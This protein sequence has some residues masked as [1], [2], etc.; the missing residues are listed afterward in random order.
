MI[1]VVIQKKDAKDCR[2]CGFHSNWNLYY[3][4]DLDS[5]KRHIDSSKLKENFSHE[6]WA[7]DDS[8]ASRR[9]TKNS[10][11]VKVEEWSE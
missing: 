3:Y 1:Y 8:N 4:K 6:L 9:I 11:T 5:A 2:A 10:K 7:V